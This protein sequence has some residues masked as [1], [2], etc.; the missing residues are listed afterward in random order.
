[1]AAA[2]SILAA[3]SSLAAVLAPAGPTGAATLVTS[4]CVRTL[5]SAGSVPITATGFTPG[6]LV[7]VRY[8]TRANPVPSYLTSGTADP[9]GDF[10]TTASA[11]GFTPFAVPTSTLRLVRPS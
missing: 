4:P 2:R 3:A 5:D 7:T 11:P 6:A 1:M 8:A 10:A 9:A